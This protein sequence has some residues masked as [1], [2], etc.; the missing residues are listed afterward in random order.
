MKRARKAIIV[1]PA[2][3]RTYP[4]GRI[5]AVFKA[6]GAETKNAYS[7][8]EWW[9]E[10]NTQGPPAHSNEDDHV[11]YVI[12]GTM[13]I[14]IGEEWI[15][16]PKGTYVVIPGGMIHTFENRSSN[17]AGIINFNYPGGFEKNLPGIAEFFAR[18]PAG[19]AV[20]TLP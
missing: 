9:I 18:I 3:G 19:D 15:D 5:T 20:K 13:G 6:D 2:D 8:S 4:M 16:A 17:R 7:V 12:E 10:P 11:W 14:F 1:R